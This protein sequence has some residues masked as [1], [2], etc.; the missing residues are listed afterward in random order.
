MLRLRPDPALML[1]LLV[2]YFDNFVKLCVGVG[3]LVEAPG[4]EL[5]GGGAEDG[6]GP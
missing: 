5:A 3:S 4:V 1:R 6:I 2:E